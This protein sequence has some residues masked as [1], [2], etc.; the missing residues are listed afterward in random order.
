[1]GIAKTQI[2]SALS[3]PLPNDIVNHLLDDY[4]EIKQNFAFR[5]FRPSELNGGRFAE[6]IIR[7]IQHLDN[8]PYTP[9]GTQLLNTDNII[10]RVENNTALHQSMRLF[11][12]RLARILLDVRN[13]RDVAHVGGDVNPNNSDSIF[14]SHTADWILT[15]ILR[16][17]YNCSIDTAKKIAESL[18]E[19]ALPIIADIDGFVRVQNTNLSF[20]EKTITILY[21]K[22]PSKVYDQD[23]IKWTKYSNASAYK[24]KIL[25]KLDKDAL[26]HYEAGLC[27]LLPKGILYAEKHIPMDILV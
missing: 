17:Y 14:I 6:S 22:N 13:R 1:M 8:P 20:E 23:L 3:P 15:E 26:I 12:P 11:I 5:K 24:K 10:R 9:F 18:N 7:I 19:F 2:I 27:T 4:I 16:I 25:G 21:Y